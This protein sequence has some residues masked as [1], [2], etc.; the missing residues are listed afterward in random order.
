MFDNILHP[1]PKPI[2]VSLWHVFPWT[3]LHTQLGSY[4]IDTTKKKKENII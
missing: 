1:N 3:D 4:K 2:I